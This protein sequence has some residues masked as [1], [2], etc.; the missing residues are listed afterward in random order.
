VATTAHLPRTDTSAFDVRT[1]NLTDVDNLRL[2]WT[3]RMQP[4]EMRRLLTIYPGRS[5]WIPQTLEFAAVGPWRHREEI[6]YLVELSAVRHPEAVVAAVEDRCVAAGDHLLLS[7]ELEEVRR[8]VFYDRI[9]FDLLEEVVTYEFAGRA[10]PEPPS[11]ALKFVQI[12]PSDD[13]ARMALLA[14]DHAAFPWLWWNSDLEFRAYGLM[15]GV[16]LWFALDGDDIVAYLGMTSFPGWGHLD[17]IAVDPGRQGS[18]IGLTA[19]HFAV[20]RLLRRGAKRIGLSTQTD[21][22]RSRRLYE[23]FGFR[24]A[25]SHDYR[26]YGRYLTSNLPEH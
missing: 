9:G 17:R 20:Q 13:A 15:P 7:V 14:L 16:E 8:P 23:R 26:L 21:N 18:G 11:R 24:R 2:G 3:A 1:L 6:A 25:A 5:V 22:E 19:L 4:E 10:R 12:D